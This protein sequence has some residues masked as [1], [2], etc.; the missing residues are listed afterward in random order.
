M[1]P[2]PEKFELI[3][4]FECEP[5][6][7]DSH[8]EWHYNHLTFITSARGNRIECEIEPA[9]LLMKLRWYRDGCELLNLNLEVVTGLKIENQGG[10]ELLRATFSETS[11][12][13]SLVIRLKPS[14]HVFM[15]L[16]MRGLDVRDFYK[17]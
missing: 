16:K 5:E 11:G 6:L 12:I 17:T 2:F 3:S 9:N 14:I 7:L 1:N 8:V 4:F 13:G 15:D 10:K